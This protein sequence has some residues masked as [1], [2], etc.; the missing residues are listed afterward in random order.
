LPKEK[1]PLFRKENQEL[2]HPQRKA[3]RMETNW[4][5]LF[6]RHARNTGKFFHFPDSGKWK[7]SP[8]QNRDTVLDRAALRL[9]PCVPGISRAL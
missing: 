5:T 9:K 1:N 2:R 7:G 3:F 8:V 6:S 4:G